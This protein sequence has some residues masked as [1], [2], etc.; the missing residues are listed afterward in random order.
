MELRTPETV[1]GRT[2]VIVRRLAKGERLSIQQVMLYA[3][4]KRSGAYALMSRISL[5]AELRLYKGEYSFVD[6]NPRHVDSEGVG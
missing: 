4:L 5:D 1:T 2:T 3:N 6:E